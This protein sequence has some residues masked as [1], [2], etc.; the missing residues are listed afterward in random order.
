MRVPRIAISE[1]NLRQPQIAGTTDYN[2]ANVA[3]PAEP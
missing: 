2:V 3:S 1:A